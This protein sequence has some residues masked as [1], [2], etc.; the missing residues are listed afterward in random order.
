MPNYRIICLF[1]FLFLSP[2]A[3]GQNTLLE[4][5]FEDWGGTVADTPLYPFSTAYTTF[6]NVHQRITEVVSSY[7]GVEPHS[8]NYFLVQN[9]SE[10]PLDPAIPGITDGSVQAYNQIGVAAQRCGQNPWDI[11]TMTGPEFYAEWWAVIQGEFP[12]DHY[13]GCKWAR[14]HNDGPRDLF[15]MMGRSDD[16]R[17]LR[18]ATP[19]DDCS[20]S[21]HQDSNIGELSPQPQDGSWHK[22]ALYVNFATGQMAAWYDEPNPTIA[23]A[24]ITS[25]QASGDFCGATKPETTFVIQGNFSAQYPSTEAWHAI[26]D[27]RI[28]DGIPTAVTT[29]AGPQDGVI[30]SDTEA[31]DTGTA[32]DVRSAPDRFQGVDTGGVDVERSDTTGGPDT[33]S[34]MDATVVPDTAVVADTATV[35]D[36]TVVSDTAVVADTAV[37]TDTAVALDTAVPLD[38]KSRS[39]SSDTKTVSEGCA[40]ATKGGK[41]TAWFVLLLSLLCLARRIK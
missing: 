18:F 9:D 40:C 5:G 8:G 21:K 2:P 19:S 26:D 17:Y 30:Q 1:L 7:D 27:I 36:T 12:V 11:D 29:D 15:L 16:R 10:T 23:N 4:Y 24:L 22:F 39:D 34:S 37:V 25:T 41:T 20:Y 3:L 28:L 33:T 32:A 31:P 14:L 38:A 6:C 13:P 35:L